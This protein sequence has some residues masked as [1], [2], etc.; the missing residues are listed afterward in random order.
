MIE[1]KE[2]LEEMRGKYV[3]IYTEHKFFGS[4]HIKMKFEPE[5]KIGYGFHCGEQIIYIRDNEVVS[6][7]IKEHGV[8]INGR[9]TIINITITS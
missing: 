2:T 1:L 7:I 9:N 8:N 6:Y 4:Q 5:T 3:D